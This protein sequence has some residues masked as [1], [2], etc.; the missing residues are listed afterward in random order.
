MIVQAEVVKPFKWKTKDGRILT[1]EPGRKIRAPRERLQKLETR[2]YV[3]VLGVEIG[4][5]E[6]SPFLD[7]VEMIGR[8]IKEIEGFYAFGALRWA[9]DRK[10]ELYQRVEALE[11]EINQLARARAL[12]LL[13]VRLEQWRET[14]RQIVKEFL[15]AEERA[16]CA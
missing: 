9:R 3:K 8:V 14:I 2:G 6:D 16:C 13:E 11:R 5:L 10:P 12:G 4:N 7:P 15:A 1:F